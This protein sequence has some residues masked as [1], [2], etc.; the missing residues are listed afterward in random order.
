M[1]AI[2]EAP[3]ICC[4]RSVSPRTLR[5]LS[6]NFIVRGTCH[7][8][9]EIAWRGVHSRAGWYVDKRPLE[10][11][12]ERTQWFQIA[13][14][15]CASVPVSYSSVHKLHSICKSRASEHTVV[16]IIVASVARVMSFTMIKY[17]LHVKPGFKF[18]YG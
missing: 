3:P 6:A 2:L 7:S 18:G 8:A 9:R 10:T 14:M 16:L 5:K 12:C 11:N 17:V 13:W 15:N 1:S 4:L